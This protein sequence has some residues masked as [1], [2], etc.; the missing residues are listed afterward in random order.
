MKF[1][2]EIEEVVTFRHSI[3]VECNSENELNKVCDEI[4]KEDLYRGS[5]YA[6]LLENKLNDVEFI[7]DGSGDSEIECTDLYEIED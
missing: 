1:K 5:D 4:E 2:L 3:I 6:L 7:E